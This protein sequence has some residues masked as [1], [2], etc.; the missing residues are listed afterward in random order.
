M[1]GSRAGAGPSRAVQRLHEG[2][3]QPWHSPNV[4][5]EC[6]MLGSVARHDDHQPDSNWQRPGLPRLA[7]PGCFLPV[8]SREP[9]V[10]EPHT[11]ACGSTTSQRRFRPGGRAPTSSPVV[12]TWPPK[13]A[14]DR[15]WVSCALISSMGLLGGNEH[16]GPMAGHVR[17]DVSSPRSPQQDFRNSETG[18]S[19]TFR[20]SSGWCWRSEQGNTQV[21]RRVMNWLGGRAD[22][23]E[24]ASLGQHVDDVATPSR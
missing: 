18:S 23:V 8:H 15:S 17:S 5:T 24:R 19:T 13:L 21:R 10:Q 11:A 12:V 14:H 3:T 4:M 9:V 16:V 1:L 7:R 6:P 20:I 2:H 22:H